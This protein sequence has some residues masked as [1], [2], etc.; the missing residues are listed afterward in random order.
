MRLGAD[1]I[2]VGVEEHVALRRE[3]LLGVGCRGGGVY[4][5]GVVE[6]DPDVADPPD[7]GLGADRRQPGLDPRVAERALLGLAA[8]MVEVHLLIRAAGHAEAPAAALAIKLPARSR[9]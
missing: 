9:R 2:V 7:A 5:V 6:H 8:A 1:G 4:A 3:Q